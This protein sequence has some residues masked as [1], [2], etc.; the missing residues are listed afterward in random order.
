MFHV[1]PSSCWLVGEADKG[2]APCALLSRQ[3]R[4]RVT[5]SP[6]V[7]DGVNILPFVQVR[8]AP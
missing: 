5:S 8:N 4:Q 1:P 2:Y 7:V 3:R 6:H